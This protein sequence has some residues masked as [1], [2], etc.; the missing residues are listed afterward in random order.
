[1]L[2]DYQLLWS[3]DTH[4]IVLIIPTKST[5]PPTHVCSGFISIWISKHQ[6]WLRKA[7][8]F[9]EEEAGLPKR[10]RECRRTNKT[11][12]LLKLIH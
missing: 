11:T 10:S 1:M 3:Q 7:Q 2:V 5:L 9:A 8:P 12:L 6:L 4:D